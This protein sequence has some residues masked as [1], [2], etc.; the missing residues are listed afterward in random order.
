LLYTKLLAPV[1]VETVEPRDHAFLAGG[2]WN[3]RSVS[4]GANFWV[5]PRVTYP[6]AAERDIDVVMVA[7][8]AA[9]K[10]HW[11]V[12]KALRTL[13]TRG[14]RLKVALV[15]YPLDKTL[16]RVRDE[17]RHFGV[18]DQITFHE[19][20]RQEEVAALLARSKVH[21]LWSRQECSN[22]A[23]IEAML[24]DVPV[25]VRKGLT[26]GYHYPYINPQTG[27]F[28]AEDDLADAILDM[29]ANRTSFSPRSWVLDHMTPQ[30][31]TAALE[32]AI[33]RE[34]STLG[35]RW[36]EGL[37][38]KTASLHSQAYWNPED[39]RRFTADYQFLESLVRHRIT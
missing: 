29:I 33:G 31:A 9:V 32:A 15:G 12:F 2:N 26:Y 27:R 14:H 1:F 21:V 36:S 8:W 18:A 4:I 30:H 20:L 25:I 13:R 10:R 24:A 3:L 5:D 28:V 16:A 37:V 6:V 38:V 17:A 23:V 34:A 22:R 7:S 35:E 19:G 11:R 39:R